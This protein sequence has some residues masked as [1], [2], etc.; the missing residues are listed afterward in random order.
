M[1]LE[2]YSPEEQLLARLDSDAASLASYP[3]TDGC[4]LH[5]IDRSGAPAGLFEDLSKVEKYEMPDSD[6]DQRSESLRSF[7]RQ[8][9]LGR[10]DVSRRPQQREQQQQLRA[11]DEARAAAIVPGGRCWVR[12]E[13][14]PCHRATVAYVGETSF[15]PGLWVGLRCDDPV[16]RHDG[17]VGGR[18]Y[19]ECPPGY[20]VFVRPHCVLRGDWELEGGGGRRR[21]GGGR[22]GGRALRGGGHTPGGV[23]AAAK[24]WFSYPKNQRRL[25]RRERPKRGGGRRSKAPKCFTPGAAE[26]AGA[27]ESGQE[28]AGRRLE[29]L[30]VVLEEP[31]TISDEA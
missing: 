22:P 28:A 11:Q 19:F 29:V 5:V 13:G 31:R 14:R 9:R 27:T 25:C 4:R 23:L 30:Q 24:F 1:D 3:V 10:F 18:R 26:R 2:L 12:L 15:K 17:S 7:L 21:G 20:G 6:Y 8:R 16:G